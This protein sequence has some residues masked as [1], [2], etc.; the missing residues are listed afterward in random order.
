MR[1]RRR[2][3][4]IDAYGEL[5]HLLLSALRYIE[6]LVVNTSRVDASKSPP[7]RSPA[8]H[9]LRRFNKNSADRALWLLKIVHSPLS[10]KPGAEEGAG[11]AY[12]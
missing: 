9:R 8:T 7:D 3:S 1:A 4:D 11:N 6:L 2:G 5:W 12:I 10:R